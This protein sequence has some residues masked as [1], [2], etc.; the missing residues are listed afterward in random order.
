MKKKSISSLELAALVNELQFVVKGKINQIYHQEKK[1]LLLQLHAPGQGKQLL[2]IIPGKFICLTETKK[3]ASLKPTGFCMQL[4]KY[5][6]NS[7]I[8]KIEQ[9]ASER[10]IVFELE[11]M[12]KY[13]LIIELFSK[14]NIVL[15]DDKYI[16]ISTL[17]W[18]KWKDRTVK[19][20]EKFVFPEPGLD[21]KKLTEKE[22]TGI[23]NKSEK[24][25]LAVSLATEIGL[26]GLYAEEVCKRN[27]IDKKKL[28]GEVSKEE[29]K[30][31][32]KTIKEFVKLVEKPAGYIY[33]NEITPFPLIDQKET[34]K[35]EM[36][37]LAI[38]IINPF[39]KISPYE[40]RIQTIEKMVKTQA[41][42]TVKLKEKIELN[43]QKG[44]LIYEKY[45]QLQKLID[46]VKELKKEKEWAE[47][48]K[49]LK[50]E[51]KI[52]SVDLKKK[53][54]CIEL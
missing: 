13:Y 3:D 52:Q 5:L 49:E 53:T 33:E 26:G 15:T 9:I 10:I 45:S 31:I 4:R 37:N 35:L 23:L 18:Q 1:E 27:E 11:K 29:I 50:K 16:I 54:V 46:I 32:V 34:K 36:Y 41:A 22:L 19:P 51:K 40:K 14:G 38:N 28:P 42:A 30:L 44:E 25:S 47:I 43:K 20:K 2:K 12:G 8:K 39:V 17:E 7:F 48:S 24:N 6:N 21:W